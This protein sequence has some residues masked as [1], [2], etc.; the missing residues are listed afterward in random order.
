MSQ[1]DY[2]N[3]KAVLSISGCFFLQFIAA[4]STMNVV[5]TTL[6]DCG[7]DNLGF[8][9]LAVIYMVFGLSS[10]IAP[11]IIKRLK[12]NL[13]MVL[14]SLCYD[15]W[16]ISLSLPAILLKSKDLKEVL[17]YNQVILIVI[18]ASAIMGFGAT[19]IW[20]GQGKYL[21]DCS[22]Q[23]I[24]RKGIYSSIFLSFMFLAS[25]LSSFLSALILGSYSQEYLYLVCTFIS[26]LSTILLIFLP[27][28][29][30]EEEECQVLRE[31][32]S[33]N[34][35]HH[36]EIGLMKLIASKQMILT[37]GISLT[38]ALSHAF[39]T[40]GLFNFLTLT[41][42]DET[43][44]NQFKQASYAQALFGVG[45]FIGSV[46]FGY[47]SEKLKSNFKMTQVALLVHVFSYSS[48]IWCNEI[49]KFGILSFC[50]CFILGIQDSFLQN[51]M[52]VIMGAE[53]TQSIEAFAIYRLFNSV[54]V[55]FILII[56]S[57][58]TNLEGFR[59]FIAGCLVFSIFS[60]A[61]MI[62]LFKF[63]Y[64]Q[65][66]VEHENKKQTIESLIQ[67]K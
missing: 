67:K 42:S 66:D 35:M 2:P 25:I 43:I 33:Q 9:S 57:N 21:S 52:Q 64:Q 39:R 15:I 29:D 20:I 16:L 34:K 55:T 46:S 26:L 19:L 62:K 12:P 47:L 22:K 59:I 23:K 5:S 58:L 56:I 3:L 65:G 41:Q 49:Y 37:Y 27:K 53:F 48:M 11:P 10:L 13:S 61:I 24:E 31:G 54:S 36:D 30:I 7:F 1:L 63:K 8:Y 40:A 28:I 38:T 4:N 6:K 51:Q 17:T 45:Q 50:T 18:I 32:Q 60:Q 14:G 44:Q